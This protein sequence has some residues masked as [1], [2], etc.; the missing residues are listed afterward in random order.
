MKKSQVGLLAVGLMLLPLAARAD[1]TKICVE[2]ESATD[3]QSVLKAV[4]PGPSP[5]YSGKGFIHIPWDKNETK[6]QGQ[7]TLKINVAKPGD[8]YVWARTF[9]E[10]GCGNSIS[11]SV[12]G[13]DRMLGEDGT[14]GSWHWVQN[15]TRVPLK[16]GLNTVILKNRETGVKVDQIFFCT[17][18]EYTPTNIRRVTNDGA[19]G[20]AIG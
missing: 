14:Y 18:S 16:A 4:T 17:D 5:K 20:K 1:N 6:G 8:Y 13:Q 3:I 11:L 2:A 7:A 10:N 12:N 19:T 15:V 9:W